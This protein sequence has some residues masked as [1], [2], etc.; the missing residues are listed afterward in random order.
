MKRN[1]IRYLV[2]SIIVIL[3]ALVGLSSIMGDDKDLDFFSKSIKDTGVF[4]SKVFYS[5]IKFVKNA[6]ETNE[7]KK[8]YIKNMLN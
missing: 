8:I 3:V 2:A 4:I 6:L 5:P 7:E 1:N